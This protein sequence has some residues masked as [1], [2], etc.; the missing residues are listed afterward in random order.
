MEKKVKLRNQPVWLKLKNN[1]ECGSWQLYSM[2]F[3]CPMLMSEIGSL[4]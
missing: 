2:T 1:D 3:F 4:L